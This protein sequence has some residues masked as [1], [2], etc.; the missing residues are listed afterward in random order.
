MKNLLTF[1]PWIGLIIFALLWFKESNKVPVFNKPGQPVKV[2]LPIE[3]TYKDKDGNEHIVVKDG[4]NEITK[5]EL[6]NPSRPANIIDS[7][8]ALLKIATAEIQRVTR[9]NS[10]TRDS[11]L[12]AKAV[13]NTQ[14]KQ[15]SY[16]Y[17]DQFVDLSFIPPADTTK[18]GI[19]NFAYNADLN[20]V[21]YQKR[22]WFLG[23]KESF[24]DI[25]SNDPRTT[26]RGVKQ[27]T[28]KQ[29][30]PQ[31]GLRIQASSNYNPQTNTFGF[32]PAARVDVGRFSFQ[33]NYTYYP[34]SGRWRPGITANFDLLRL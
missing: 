10:L 11:L 25:S 18:E 5:A 4:T 16:V 13:I 34:A 20:I 12:K 21:Q 2:D 33:G 17:K 8:A 3:K 26:I 9:I 19:F 23:A 29:E 15:L 1:A 32:G 14:T 24:I 31:F 28:V 22:R 6:K 7:S 27:L 30:T